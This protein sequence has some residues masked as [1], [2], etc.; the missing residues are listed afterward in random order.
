MVISDYGHHPA[1]IRATLAAAREGFGRRLVVLFQP[2]RYTRTRDLFG[3][4][5]DAF[6]A[7]D[8]LRADRHL[9]RRRGA[10]RRAQRRGAVLG[11][12]SGAATS[13]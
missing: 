7:A 2:H 9:R 6:D 8:Q 3:E 5:L 12:A 1:E 4:F 13:R 10:G 11:A